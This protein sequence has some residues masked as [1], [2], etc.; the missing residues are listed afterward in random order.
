MPEDLQ[1]AT[2]R[3]SLVAC[4]LA[5]IEALCRDRQEAEQLLDVELPPDWPDPELAEFLPVVATELRES[6]AALG[7]GVPPACRNRGYATEAVRE[8]TTW[9]LGQDGVE[10]VIA[11]CEPDNTPSLR[12]LAKAGLTRA[13]S[14]NGLTRW[15]I[16]PGPAS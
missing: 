16:R 9:V 10:R 11:H 14:R 7:Y 12:V 5:M 3:L 6:P 15:I 13:G 8:L 2:G 4:S 1:I